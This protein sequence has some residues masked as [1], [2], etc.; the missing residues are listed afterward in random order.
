MQELESLLAKYEKKVAINFDNCNHRVRCFAH[1]INI[2]LSH[3]ISSMTSVSKG[4]LS[5]LNVPLNSDPTV[6][7]ND[8]VDVD[9][10][11][12]PKLKLDDCYHDSGN[13]NLKAFFA[14][15]KHDPLR[16]ACRL[17]CFLRSSDGRREGFRAFIKL[18][19]NK[20][21]YNVPE[22]QLLR[23]VKTRWDSVYK[24]LEHLRELRPVS[25]SWALSF[26]QIE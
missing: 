26:T 13:P 14:G 15:I 8:D 23:D 3:V 21:W 10:D 7:H 16:R 24:M 20:N 12:V 2:C 25:S 17:I 6:C 9:D 18:G 5:D 19:N 1:I 22:K 4:Y 11:D